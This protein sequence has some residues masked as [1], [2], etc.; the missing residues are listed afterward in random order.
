MS[1]NNELGYAELLEG[2]FIYQ[3]EILFKESKSLNPDLLQLIGKLAFL[4]YSSDT[5][6]NIQYLEKFKTCIES[7]YLP[8]KVYEELEKLPNIFTDINHISETEINQFFVE[9]FSAKLISE[10]AYYEFSKPET[11]KSHYGLNYLFIILLEVDLHAFEIWLTKTNR[12]DLKIIFLNL[13]SSDISKGGINI[14]KL[15]K[16]NIG[17]IQTFYAYCK[18][19]LEP[20]RRRRCIHPP[21]HISTLFSSSLSNE[22]KCIIFLEFITNQYRMNTYEQLSNDKKFLENLEYFDKL[23]INSN[24]F[25]IKKDSD[26]VPVYL[27][28]I[29]TNNNKKLDKIK[30]LQ[31]LVNNL[32][33]NMEISSHSFDYDKDNAMLLGK[34]S[35]EMGSCE[36]LENR[37]EKEFKILS[38]PYSF[39]KIKNWTKKMEFCFKLFSGLCIYKKTKGEDVTLL[40]DKVRLLLS[41]KHHLD[42]DEMEKYIQKIEN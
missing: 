42:Y 29:Q 32:I 18:F 27:K 30:L 10:I 36:T 23:D 34:I 14:D 9:P 20:L 12:T 4:A 35:L 16:S 17:I 2:T 41:G 26:L 11:I 37:F 19:E 24:D 3:F 6:K 31:E 38:F 25:I 40:I 33:E 7:Y 1:L 13:L 39:C 28:L 22:H 8:Q 15:E 21:S 5:K